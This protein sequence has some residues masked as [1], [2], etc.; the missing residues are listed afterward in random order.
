M[1]NDAGL[2]VARPTLSVSGTDRPELAEALLGLLVVED[3]DGL[4]RCEALFGNWGEKNGQI[5]YLYFNRDLLEFGKPM[6]VK[7]GT[8]I[9]F[10]GRIMA[11]EGRFPEGRA[12]EIQVLAEDRFQDLRMTRRTRTFTDLTDAALFQN[13]ARDHGLTPQV[14]VTGPTHKVLAQV[15]QTD[16]AFLRD[17]ARTLD[18][19]L[20]LEGATLHVQSHNRRATSSMDLSYKGNLREFVVL[21]DLAHQRTSVVVNGWDV[22]SKTAIRQKSAASSIQG[23][24][25]GD[26]SGPSILAQALGDRKQSLAHTV[27]MTDAEAQARADSLFCQLA[28]RFVIGHGV[29]EADSRLRAGRFV[30]LAGLGPL[31]NGRY[32][33]RETRL[34]FDN[35]RGIRSEFTAERPGLGH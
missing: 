1:P 15:N 18:A 32:A 22:A 3:I 11:L 14:D 28:R 16:L 34:V 35:V 26:T 29:A 2:I 33:L 24:L 23:E 20:W 9:V 7:L 19:E 5:D 27:P 4:A 17:R 10:E 25:H 21:A 12:P 6:V 30:N 8:D 31:F 13:L